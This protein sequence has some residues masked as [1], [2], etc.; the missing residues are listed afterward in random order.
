V[1][2]NNTYYATA[3][4]NSNPN[5][6]SIHTPTVQITITTN[7]VTTPET[8]CIMGLREIANEHLPS[9]LYRSDVV[10]TFLIAECGGNTNSAASGRV[11]PEVKSP[12]DSF[13]PIRYE[14]A[15]E[16]FGYL[17]TVKSYSTFSLCM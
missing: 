6:T 1:L 14:S 9:I 16:F 4:T 10:S 15:V 12:F 2:L 13:T 5:P 8:Q 17:L 7:F 11:R 3:K